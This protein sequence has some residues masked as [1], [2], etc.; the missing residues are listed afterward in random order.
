MN[1]MTGYAWRERAD[2]AVSVSV[3]IKGYNN[4]FLEVS[5]N[6][7]PWLPG[8]ETR[9][10]ALVSGSC[11]RGRVE[12]SIRVRETNAPV[13]VTVNTT[14]ARAYMKAISDLSANLG[15]ADNISV[16]TL[17][18]MEGVL[19]AEKDR[20]AGRYWNAIEPVLRE[21]VS[22]FAAERAREGRHTEGDILA[23][24]ARI[25]SALQ[26]VANHVPTL[27]A[28]IRENVGARFRELTGGSI[29]E[30]RVMA[31]TAVLLMKYTVSEE[32]SRLSS[33]LGEF[34]AE[35]A[36]ND[37]PGK[38]LDF[39]CQEINRE[40]NTIGSK[41]TMTEVSRAVVDMKEALE[42]AREQL[43]NIE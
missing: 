13:N 7:P 8:L 43:R 22:A 1:S 27:E 20:D 21:A 37:R 35:A 5:V 23:S 10:R 24:V 14:A 15:L 42:N 25:E 38:K 4:R 9:A 26:T 28:S 41:S 19:E 31:E 12:V 17:I 2:D 3:E 40:I 39:L 36:R 29:D 34:R 32:I 30:N 18:G 16:S 11:G 6:A 33:H